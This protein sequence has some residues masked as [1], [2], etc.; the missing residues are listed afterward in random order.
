M[1]IES[2]PAA[3]PERVPHELV[4]RKKQLFVSAAHVNPSSFQ[5]P[6]LLLLVILPDDLIA[7]ACYCAASPR[8]ELRV[9][10]SRAIKPEQHQ[11]SR[12]CRVVYAYTF[13]RGSLAVY[14]SHVSPASNIQ[15]R[16]TV[17]LKRDGTSS[18][19]C[20]HTL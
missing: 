1:V 8:E 12:T 2:A 3:V 18:S 15:H 10:S 7:H 13:N 11:V 19:K 5:D 14:N 9:V 17:A 6:G 16:V 4:T 20:V